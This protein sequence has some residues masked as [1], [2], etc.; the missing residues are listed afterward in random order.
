MRGGFE[1]VDSFEEEVAK[2]T[3]APYAIATESCTS[4]LLLCCAYH[5]VEEVTIPS[6]TYVGVPNSIVH[7]GGSVEFEDIKWRGLYNLHPY[8]IV[9]SAKRFTSDMY[10]SGTYMCLSFHVKKLLPIGRGG[11]ILT[12]DADSV[13]WF[14]KAR[15]DGRTE[16]V[17]LNKCKFDSL[18]WNCYMT[19]EQAARGLQ[20]LSLYPKDKE[21]LP[22]ENYGDLSQYEIFNNNKSR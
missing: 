15:H 6:N 12:D 16:G 18:G 8:P 11:M 2:Y 5:K 7:A 13:E 17:P 4:A 10:I 14:K 19:P 22:V 20:L 21:D 3:G 9:D 1:I